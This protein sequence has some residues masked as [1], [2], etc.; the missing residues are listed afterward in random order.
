MTPQRLLKYGIVPALTELAAF[1]IPD[2]FD[3]RRILVAIALQESRVAHRRQVTENGAENGPAASFWQFEKGGGCAGVLR[4]HA[5]ADSMAQICQFFN[6]EPTAAALWEAMR[7]NDI[8]AAAAARLLIYTLPQKLP[9]TETQ[10]WAQYIDAWRPG[11]PHIKTWAA[12]WLL[13]GQIVRGLN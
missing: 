8:V 10:G 1:G 3:A 6:V 13:A 5:S 4:H 11:K 7:Y 2:S 9:L 12:N